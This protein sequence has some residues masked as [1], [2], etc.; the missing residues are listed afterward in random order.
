MNEQNMEWEEVYIQAR[1]DRSA[2]TDNGY[3]VVTFSQW[4]PM[5]INDNL[6]VH[7]T[8][9]SARCDV[10]ECKHDWSWSNHSGKYHCNK[11]DAW[12]YLGSDVAHSSESSKPK[13]FSG[14]STE[15][16]QA[17]GKDL[18]GNLIKH[19]IHGGVSAGVHCSLCGTK[20]GNPA[21]QHLEALDKKEM[22]KVFQPGET[23]KLPK[24]VLELDNLIY[25]IFDKIC[26]KFGRPKTVT[27]VDKIGLYT[28]LCHHL[29]EDSNAY[30]IMDD[31]E[32]LM[33][34]TPNKK[35]LDAL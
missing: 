35:A 28:I 4:A 29:K 8:H 16:P 1:L 18:D 3:S 11:C 9:E 17:T 23:I 15:T 20:L 22:W 14:Y 10:K 19:D 6:I 13:Q 33:L 24:N 12:S 34:N 26:Q 27:S 30:K 31:I 25:S 32:K 2:K 5:I 21:G 7:R